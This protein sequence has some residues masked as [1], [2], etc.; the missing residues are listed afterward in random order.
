M[1]LQKKKIENVFIVSFFKTKTTDNTKRPSSY[2]TS[3][4]HCSSQDMRA[5]SLFDQQNPHQHLFSSSSFHTINH[6]SINQRIDPIANA[7]MI[8][9]DALLGTG[10]NEFE[11]QL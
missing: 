5:L 6:A 10:W 8:D 3:F 2:G 9:I 7:F 1:H 11:L 4:R